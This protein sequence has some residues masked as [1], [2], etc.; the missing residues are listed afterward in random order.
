MKNAATLLIVSAEPLYAKVLSAHL[1]VQVE[2]A[3]ALEKAATALLLLPE[4]LKEIMQ[5]DEAAI[6]SG[7]PSLML[8]PEGMRAQPQCRHLNR[9]IALETLR[10][11]VDYL[12]QQPR[13]LRW[14]GLGHFDPMSMHLHNHFG[15]G[16]ALTEKEA[17]LLN[18]LASQNK[19]VSAEILLESLWH[20][21]RDAETHTF[22]THLYRLRQKLEA[23]FSDKLQIIHADAGYQLIY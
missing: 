11:E 21:H 17:A 13:Q 16:M 18:F 5:M 8:L 19:P 2:P 23:L 10:G 14:E 12:L 9:P 4:S 20:Y 22:D 6:A 15:Q 3:K 7:V 1:R